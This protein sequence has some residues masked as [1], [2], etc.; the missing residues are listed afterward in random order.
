M[1]MKI[2][3]SFILLLLAT[4]IYADIKAGKEVYLVNCA[5]C[6][7]INMSGSLGKDF[8]IVSYTRTKEEII[9]YA[10]KPELVFRSFGYPANAMPTLPLD[11]EEIKN[12]A[13]YIDS[14][15][16]FKKWMKKSQ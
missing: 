14:L 3:L 10:T 5:N 15:Q 6:H 12:V 7:S 2:K 11:E 1:K 13:D 4:N 8:N 16:P 9:A